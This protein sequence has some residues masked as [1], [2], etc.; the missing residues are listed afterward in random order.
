MEAFVCQAADV[1]TAEIINDE[2][3]K[4]DSINSLTSAEMSFVGGGL[5]QV[6][7]A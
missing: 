6:V 2:Q 1:N 3:V 5:M 4:A 7:F